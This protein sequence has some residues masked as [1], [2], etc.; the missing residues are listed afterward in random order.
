MKQCFKCG[1]VKP[2]DQFYKHS[3]MGDGRLNKCI[4][5]TKKDVSE[6]L[7][8]L[9]DDPAFIEK[10]RKRGRLK[11]HRLYKGKK[12]D[13]RQAVIKHFEKYPERYLGKLKS[14]RLKPPFEKA[15]RH[16]WSYN[17][18]HLA[19]VIWLNKNNHEKAHRFLVYDKTEKKFRRSDNKE[20]LETKDQHLE[21][22]NYCLSNF[23]D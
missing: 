2:L 13:C 8:V 22:I 9:S 1:T 7:L 21:W 5:C 4:D 15:Q 11:H 17:D 23:E 20:L 19:D 18:D 3:K 10:E 14:Q 6:R 16:H 12:K